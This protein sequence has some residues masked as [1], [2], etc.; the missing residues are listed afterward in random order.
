MKP[1]QHSTIGIAALLLIQLLLSPNSR[2]GQPG[3]TDEG[4]PQLVRHGN[5]AQL[6]VDG[7]PFLIIGGELNN[8]TSSSLEYMRPMWQH[9]ADL[10]FNT[11]VTPL[12]W[13]LIEPKEGEFDFS[14]VDGLIKEA[15]QD[16]MH[17]VFLWL[18][19]WKNGMSTYVPLSGKGELQKIS[20][21]N[22]SERFNDRSSFYIF[23][24]Q[25]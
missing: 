5:V 12:S 1:K 25:R 15:R 22:N 20:A 16:R 9:V 3:Q 13:E 23:G 19:S 6:Y 18:A 17:L 21:C 7:K 24:S 4:M 11:V 10:N 2:A 8:S 14:L